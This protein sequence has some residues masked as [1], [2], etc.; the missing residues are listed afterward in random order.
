M[1]DPTPAYTKSIMKQKDLF[2]SKT[3]EP[4]KPKTKARKAPKEQ[5]SRC[6]REVERIDAEEHQCARCNGVWLKHHAFLLLI[7]A[8]P[9]DQARNYML[10]H[11]NFV[12]W[13]ARDSDA[14]WGEH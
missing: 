2:E 8:L 6:K 4:I 12:A 11:D 9:P 7:S 3:S 5:C 14:F 10:M 13:E 1:D